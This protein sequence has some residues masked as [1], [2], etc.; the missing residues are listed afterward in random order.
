MSIIETSIRSDAAGRIAELR[1]LALTALARMYRPDERL[2]AF[3]VRRCPDGDRL[4]GASQRYTAIVLIALARE[5]EDVARRILAGPAAEH[6]LEHLVERI[7]RA[8][9]LGEVALTLWAARALNDGKAAVALARLRAMEPNKGRYPTVELAWSLTA[10]TVRSDE[11]TDEA[12]AASIAE[13]LL[14]SFREGS[15]LFPHWPRDAQASFLR[16]HVSCFADAVY[17]IQALSHYYQASGRREAL[18]AARRCARQ[19]CELQGPAG[20]WWWHYDVR[21]GRVIE[22]YPVYSVHQDAMAPMA[23]SAFRDAGGPDCEAAAVRGLQWIYEPPELGRP[24]VDRQAGVIWRKV[25][26]CEP[27][28]L[29]RTMRALAS[30]VHPSLGVPGLNGLCPPGRVD[31]ECRPYHLGWLLYAWS[32]RPG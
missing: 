25:A 28:K 31:Y 13:R 22:G 12:L 17:P 18:A 3:R 19:I 27:N 16:S 11:A 10:L 14:A 32:G 15:G 26:R 20:Q 21:T 6:V 5:A 2:F 8:H 9:D 23:L 7:G 29:S 30:R 24:L 4:E 1:S